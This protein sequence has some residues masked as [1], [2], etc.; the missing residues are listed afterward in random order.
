MKKIV[1]IIFLAFLSGIVYAKPISHFTFK[2]G[3]YFS[4]GN[5]ETG[6]E[7]NFSLNFWVAHIESDLFLTFSA[8]N[9]TLKITPRSSNVINY[10][11]FDWKNFTVEYGATQTHSKFFL[12]PWDVGKRPRGW[13]SEIKA[14][15]GK[16][17]LF[18]S[19]DRGT[20]GVR[21]IC[22][23]FFLDGWWYGNN[24]LFTVGASKGLLSLSGGNFNG[25]SIV[26]VEGKY[27]DFAVS[28]FGLSDEEMLFP[29]V[30]E[31]I[32]SRYVGIISY[33]SKTFKTSFAMSEN[34][35]YIDSLTSFELLKTNVTLQ[36]STEYINAVPIVVKTSGE[37]ELLKNIG[38]NSSLFLNASYDKTTTLWLGI[39]WRF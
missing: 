32:P 34:E 28:L 26:G 33:N 14:G 37:I 35:F 21:Y 39:E 23:L 27:G 19:L 15:N 9:N 30:D 10:A 20:Y 4:E 36:L 7:G 6:V 12:T 25:S 2:A 16:N 29:N 3:P 31:Q 24:S 8:T 17:G 18:F 1:F 11:K 38:K 22:P 13:K 5:F